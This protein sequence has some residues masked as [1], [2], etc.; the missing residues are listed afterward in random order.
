MVV[1]APSNKQLLKETYKLKV[2][3]PLTYEEL[4]TFLG[5]LIMDMV[6]HNESITV[7]QM[8]S[9]KS[10]PIFRTSMNLSRFAI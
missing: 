7:H 4:D 8:W 5:L 1:T 6:C 9:N 10:H 2:W 3:T